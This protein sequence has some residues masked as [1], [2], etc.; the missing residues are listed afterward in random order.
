MGNESSTTRAK[1]AFLNGPKSAKGGT[2]VSDVSFDELRK[3]IGK[4]FA[5]TEKIRGEPMLSWMLETSMKI[6]SQCSKAE[7]M[8]FIMSIFINEELAKKGVAFCKKTEQGDIASTVL[9]REWS[10]SSETGL[11]RSWTKM[12][13]KIREVILVV[14]LGMAGDIPEVFTSKK[15]KDDAKR[16]IIQGK[17][18]RTVQLPWHIEHGPKGKHWYVTVVGTS[19]SCQGQGVGSEMMNRIGELA[20]AERMDCY[21]K[22]GKENLRFYEKC[23]FREVATK[24]LPDQINTND[25]KPFACSLMIRPHCGK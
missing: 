5:R 21:L 6:P 13:D 23:G 12:V 2:W 4:S 20:D 14:R 19:P 24:M 25:G 22:C 8:T 11:W 18:M 17:A 16:F 7:I 1:A 9:V 15:F 10:I 3:Q